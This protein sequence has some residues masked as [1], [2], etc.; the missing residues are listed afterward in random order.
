M[1]KSS[2]R[3]PLHTG[4][5][6]SFVAP[7]QARGV[8][9]RDTNRRYSVHLDRCSESLRGLFRTRWRLVLWSRV[10]VTMRNGGRPVRVRLGC[11]DSGGPR[12]TT[13]A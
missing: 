12:W 1:V 7:Q 8:S 9:T 5:L 4:V 13:A 6:R 10:R 11:V 2:V 3:S